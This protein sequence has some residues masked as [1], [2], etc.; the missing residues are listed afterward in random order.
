MFVE[1]EQFKMVKL[2]AQWFVFGLLLLASAAA[3]PGC[4]P[5]G[6]KLDPVSGIVTLSGAP[7]KSGTITL[8]A[9]ASKG[10][11]EQ[12]TSTGKIE[13]DGRYAI[14]TDGKEGAPPGWY[15]A[16]IITKYPAARRTR[17]FSTGYTRIQK[18]RLL[19][20]WWQALSPGPMTSI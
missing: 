3:T 20:R 6:P 16:I 18:R 8:I 13:S 10:N 15:K 4:G 14:S 7:L 1:R 19:S 5:A 2:K 12:G 9:D 17:S 11:T